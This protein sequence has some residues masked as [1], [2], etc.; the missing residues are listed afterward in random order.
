MSTQEHAV[1][2]GLGRCPWTDLRTGARC[3]GDAV[4]VLLVGC[5]HEHSRELASCQYHVE[6]IALGYV[7]CRPCR[8]VDGH[9][10]ELQ[11]MKDMTEGAE[12]S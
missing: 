11:V 5:L 10:C 7:A 4:I 6:S 3:E 2:G 9:F 8:D 1:P 12:E